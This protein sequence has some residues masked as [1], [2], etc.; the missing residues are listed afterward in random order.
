MVSQL[1]TDKCDN[2]ID[3]TNLTSQSP[4]VV[5][6]RSTAKDSVSNISSIDSAFQHLAS[7]LQEGFNL[8]KPELLT[9]DGKP[10]DYS[11]FITNF[12]THVESRIS[13]NSMRLIYLIQY[14][15]SEAKSSI[16]DCILLD[17]AE[18]YKHA[19]SILHL[20]NGRSHLIATYKWFTNQDT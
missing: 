11:K 7:T 9:S 2:L 10:I 12:E 20:R 13:D 15:R 14:C 18:V 5:F 3:S 19:R 4:D 17:P 8:P 6:Q 16:E 1:P